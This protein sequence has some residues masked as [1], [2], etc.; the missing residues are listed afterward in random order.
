MQFLEETNLKYSLDLKF[1]KLEASEVG[2]WAKTFQVADQ[3]KD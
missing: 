2:L 3:N 1:I